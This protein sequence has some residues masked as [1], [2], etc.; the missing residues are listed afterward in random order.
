[1]GVIP[2]DGANGLLEIVR[3]NSPTSHLVGTLT[4]I[5]SMN[6][7]TFFVRLFTSICV[8]TSFLGVAIS[9]TDF[10]ADGLRLKKKGGSSLII[11]LLAFLPPL[12]IVLVSSN[13]F[14]K[15]LEYAGLYCIILLVLFPAWMAWRGRYHLAM[16]NS[17]YTVA[18]GRYL[19]GILIVFSILMLMRSVNLF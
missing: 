13:I 2:L 19:P 8:V 5:V 17:N 12:L 1:M 11:H 10:L 4:S 15:S 3:S 9:L 16:A 14:V 7:V 18:G 6:S